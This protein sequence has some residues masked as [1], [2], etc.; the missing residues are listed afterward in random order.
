VA[1]IPAG[2][3]YPPPEVESAVLRIDVAGRPTV[4]VEDEAAFFRAVRA[5]FGQR[6]K[7]LRNSLRAGLALD[8]A[9]VERA[10]AAARVDPDRRAET[11][12]LDEWAAVTLALSER[13]S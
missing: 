8:A 2:A 13:P 7:T 6:R 9:R 12:S 3:F 11:L 10:L 1:R 4:A 5:G